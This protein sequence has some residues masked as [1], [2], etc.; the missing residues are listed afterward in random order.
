MLYFF[1]EDVILRHTCDI[2]QPVAVL[3]IFPFLGIHTI[4]C[5]K[6]VFSCLS[7]MYVKYVLLI[8]ITAENNFFWPRII[9]KFLCPLVLSV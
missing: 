7:G 5:I 9:P 4:T 2:S 8:K 6:L 3:E 1:K